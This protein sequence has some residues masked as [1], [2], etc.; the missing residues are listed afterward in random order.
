MNTV[1]LVID[2]LLKICYNKDVSG[3]NETGENPFFAL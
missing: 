1:W 3:K 2:F